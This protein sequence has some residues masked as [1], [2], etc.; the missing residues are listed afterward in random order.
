MSNNDDSKLLGCI[1]TILMIPVISI[2]YG[3]VVRTYWSW[4]VIPAIP[5]ARPL[6]IPTALGV[7]GLV[8]M[9]THQSNVAKEEK[10]GPSMEIV[11]AFVKCGIMYLAGWTYHQF[12]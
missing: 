9:V 3:L 1:G 11:N 8:T 2:C 5:V 10:W 7:A 12:Q 6:S 4:F